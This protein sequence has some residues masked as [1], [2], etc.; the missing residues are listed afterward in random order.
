MSQ[1]GGE[2]TFAGAP[3]K[4]PLNR[5]WWAG[6]PAQ[7][8]GEQPPLAQQATGCEQVTAVDQ[9]RYEALKVLGA[10]RAGSFSLRLTPICARWGR[11][12]GVDPSEGG[13]AHCRETGRLEFVDAAPIKAAQQLEKLPSV[14]FTHHSQI[15][16]QI[17][18]AATP[19]RHTG[20][21]ICLINIT[22]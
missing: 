15:N 8:G 14:Y 13:G 18:S 7:F 17:A 16:D 2:E 22:L 9:A 1:K 20:L 6:E 11:G 10:G 4:A 12:R 21:I 3:A 19:W 5:P